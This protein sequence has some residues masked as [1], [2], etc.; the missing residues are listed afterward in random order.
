MSTY[1]MTTAYVLRTSL[2]GHGN[3]GV[4]SSVIIRRRTVPDVKLLCMIGAAS[5]SK[6]RASKTGQRHNERGSDEIA[7]WTL[8]R[9]S[10][11][12]I[13]STRS[14]RP[15]TYLGDDELWRAAQ[16]TGRETHALGGPRGL[17]PSLGSACGAS[18]RGRGREMDRRCVQI[19]ARPGVGDAIA[20]DVVRHFGAVASSLSLS[21][22]VASTFHL[23]LLGAIS[24]G[25]RV[26][27]VVG[28]RELQGGRGSV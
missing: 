13:L 23:T 18:G 10:K 2:S 14:S 12:S 15:T 22:E 19:G 5:G 3:Q 8:T 9:L 28:R 11:A 17:D 21:T 1:A 16:R 27:S 6:L 20:A 25:G 4:S 7:E 26:D 24:F